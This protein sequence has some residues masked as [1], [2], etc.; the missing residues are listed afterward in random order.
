VI[1]I[2]NTGVTSDPEEVER[3]RAEFSA[4]NCVRFPQLLDRG[5]LDFV[6][7][8]FGECRWKPNPHSDPGGELGLDDTTDDPVTLHLLYFAANL[9]EFRALIERITRSVPL[10]VFRGRL[11]RKIAGSN[12]YNKWHDDNVDNRRIAMSINL[13]PRGYSGGL[14]EMRKRGTEETEMRVANTGYGD[15]II[16]RISDQLEHRVTDV[17]GAEPKVAFAGWFRNDRPGF[18]ADVVKNS[19]KAKK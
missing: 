7:R 9:P 4:A 15:A 16:F 18:I 6:Q 1:Q 14:L 11:Y 17:E 10:D 3:L 12:H 8:R 2:S 5:L 19:K 13:S